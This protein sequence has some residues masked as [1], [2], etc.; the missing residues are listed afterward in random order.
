MTDSL[1]AEVV[2]PR[3]KSAWL[4][5]VA[6]MVPLAA[7][8]MCERTERMTVFTPPTL[9]TVEPE[10]QPVPPEPPRVI[11][12]E[13]KLVFH[14]GTHSYVKLSATENVP[15]GNATI[16]KDESAVHAFWPLASDALPS[17][18]G[19]QVF[20]DND[21][22]ATITSLHYVSRMSIENLEW[23]EE[24]QSVSKAM[25]ERAV[26]IAGELDGCD[27]TYARSASLPKVVVP[28]TLPDN[29]ELVKKA[30][31]E[32]LH[33]PAAAATER[34]WVEDY[35]STEDWKAAAMY[36]IRTF[37]HP[38]TKQ[39]WMSIHAW[40]ES[41]CGDPGVNIW[42]LFRVDAEGSLMT[43]Q[44]RDLGTMTKIHQIIDI[45]GDGGFELIGQPWMPS[46]TIV[47]ESHGDV[48]ETLE[49]PYDGCPC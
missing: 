12:S 31:R 42:G 47:T 10:V 32:L 4:L 7:L 36:D 9:P 29:A 1:R 24:G 45:E 20:V 15:T 46:D 28:E 33:S 21:C 34:E 39:T 16:V 44:I 11:S 19:K 48:L 27:G 22:T 43:I 30:K 14:A 13:L 38:L 26:F 5:L 18:V 3:R 49:L 6:P 35:Q 8:S 37:R 25:A 23:L 41:G 40:N 2:P 17:W